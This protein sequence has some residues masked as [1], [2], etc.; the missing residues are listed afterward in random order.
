MDEKSGC[1]VSMVKNPGPLANLYRLQPGI[2][3]ETRSPV[4]WKGKTHCGRVLICLDGLKFFFFNS[5]V[6]RSPLPRTAQSALHIMLLS[7]YIGMCVFHE[8]QRDMT[9]VK[10]NVLEVSIFVKSK[11]KKNGCV[12]DFM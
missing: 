3:A 10:H 6:S 2:Y 1:S 11:M 12:M 7:Y 9:S 4:L 5:Y 8:R